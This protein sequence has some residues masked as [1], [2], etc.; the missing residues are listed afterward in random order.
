MS[1]AGS[2]VPA[3]ARSVVVVLAAGSGSRLD[4]EVPKAFAE[5]GGR[6]IVEVAASAA[7]RSEAVDALVVTVPAGMQEQAAR[8]LEGVEVPVAVVAGAGSRHGSVA[9]AL[10]AIPDGAEIIVCHDAARVL[11]PPASFTEVI[12]ALRVSGAD[13]VVPGVAMHDTIKRV[14]DGVVAE[15]VPRDD[16]RAAQTPQAFRAPALRSAHERAAA[17]GEVF[18]DDAAA[19]E[20]DGGRVVVIPGDEKNFKI[21]NADDLRRAD[22]L[23]SGAT[24]A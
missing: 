12:D 16:L 22:A 17:T 3:A 5:V 6:P 21:T 8:L 4:A 11:A 20:A 18:T 13:G 14:R 7:G 23:M 2:A 9:A 1:T 15:T 19:V 24:R 10:R